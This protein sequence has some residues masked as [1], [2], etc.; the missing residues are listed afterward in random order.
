[1]RLVLVALVA[2][3]LVAAGDSA[4]SFLPAD[5]KVVIGIRVSAIR[6]S[7]LFKDAGTDAQKLSE[8]WTKLVAIAG[9]DPLRDIDEVLIFSSADNEKAGTLMA[10]RG[11]F[12]LERMAAGAERYQGV[13]LVGGPSGQGG[14]SVVA[15]L[16]ATTAVVGEAPAVRAAIDRRGH[17]APLDPKLAARVQSLAER[18]DIWGTGERPEGFIAPTGKREDLDSI[19]RFEFGIRI[20]KGLEIGAEVHAKSSKDADKLAASLAMLQA[21]MIGRE[22][23]GPKFDLQVKDGTIKLSLAVSE[24]DLKKAIAA[25]RS[26]SASK[27]GTAPKG[28]PPV[29]GSKFTVGMPPD[30]NSNQTNVFVL[31]GKK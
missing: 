29:V 19:D 8:D 5:T 2:A 7:A 9:F 6:E 10:V 14:T 20:S 12:N 23:A 11:R 3:R 22:P 30:T 28:A 15:L 18:F 27:V 21:M 1:M 4:L 13:P 17:G 16:D 31:P 26:A 25:Q 24:D